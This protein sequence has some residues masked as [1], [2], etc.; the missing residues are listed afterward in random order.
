MPKLEGY[1]A[2]IQAERVIYT[3]RVNV[4]GSDV[5]TRE[6]QHDVQ[7]D[8]SLGISIRVLF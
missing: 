2:S 6:S 4:D 7:S 5:K 1:E 3:V 8:L